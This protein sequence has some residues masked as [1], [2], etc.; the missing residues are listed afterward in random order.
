MANLPIS[1]LDAGVA[2]SDTDL[3][4]NV[5]VVGVGPVK[6]TAQQIKTYVLTSP[7][8]TGAAVFGAGA[9]FAS[10]IS[11]SGIANSGLITTPNITVSSSATLNTVSAASLNLSGNLTVGGDISITGDINFGVTNGS[12]LFGNSTG[13]ISQDNSN[14]YWDDTNNRLS[15][16]SGTSPSYNLQVTG[17]CRV[18][19]ASSEGFQSTADNAGRDLIVGKS[20]VATVLG[21][22]TDGVNSAAMVQGSNF[23]LSVNS[24]LSLQ[25]YGGYVGIGTVNPTAALYISDP[26]D[27]SGADAVRMVIRAGTGAGSAYGGIRFQTREHTTGWGCDIQ[28]V[29]D[30]SNAGGAMRF[31]TG[32][33]VSTVP[34]EAMR[35]SS[36]RNVGVRNTNPGKI[37]SVGQ[38]GGVNGEIGV[39]GNVS[40]V[41]TIQSQA[42]AGTYNFN[43]PT[44]SGTAGQVL[45]SAGGGSSPMTW[46]SLEPVSVL[47]YGA[48]N[49]G[50][51]NCATAFTN[52]NAAPSILIPSGTY[53]VS[54]NVTFTKHVT[55]LDGA[56]LNISNGVTVTFNAGMAADRYQIFNPTGTGKV[57]FDESQLT[58]GYPEWWGGFASA[59]SVNCYTAIQACIEACPITS[60]GVGNYYIGTTIKVQ[61]TGRILRGTNSG[62]QSGGYVSA[63]LMND[64]SQT[65]IQIGPD[66]YPSGGINDFLKSVRVEYLYFARTA[67]PSISGSATGLRVQ[68]CL[69]TYI[70]N[71]QISENIIGIDLSGTVQTHV[72]DV[73]VFRNLTGSGV[74]PDS[75]T[76]IFLNGDATISAAG[77]NAS[78]Y[79]TDCTVLIGGYPALSS[80]NSRGIVIGYAG[81]D[82]FLL[83][84][85]VNSCAI[86]IELLGSTG[87]PKTQTGDVDIHIIGAIVD[88]FT[89]WG[90]RVANCDSYASISIMDGYF[91]PGSGSGASAGIGIDTCIGSVSLTNNQTIGWPNST[92][93]GL[94]IN[95]SQ[96]V[97][98]TGNIYTGC[99]GGGVLM[100][101]ASLCRIQDICNNPAETSAS[102]AVTLTNCNR[103][104]IAP[105]IDGGSNVW[106]SGVDLTGTGNTY[107]EVNVTAIGPTSINGGANDKLLY[108]ATQITAVGAFPTSGTN[109]CSGCVG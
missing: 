45:A 40:G 68:W 66:T 89:Q 104:Y 6:T 12:V 29:D 8:I 44:T 73:V 20:T 90:I 82:T 10:P 108:N 57:V 1:G 53:L 41:V 76:G 22:A 36:A 88:V 23:N 37:F 2:V 75:F 69:Y 32:T 102:A 38:N 18:L 86:G 60:F 52:A 91:A 24:K 56:V 55:I 15:I 17:N 21:Y 84:P 58:T 70:E 62:Y 100:T 67:N 64:A 81:A 93:Q 39:Y 33:G 94:Y 59:G 3:L 16:A 30:T 96:G 31:R 43:L 7:S 61:K 71:C 11:T 72:A 48:D 109:Y 9:T 83:R 101:G 98:A 95:N 42:A 14:F 77:G 34:S 13:S 47:V 25:P 51:A 35:I 79:I 97:I 4:P 105:T 78:T 85:E 54:S 49:T 99:A 92:C 74:A 87:H 80:S 28:A 65:L 26:T 27:D 46:T 63:I 103:C 19:N 106:A 50:A 5:Q 107:I